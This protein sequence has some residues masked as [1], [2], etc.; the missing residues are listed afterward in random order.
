MK[1]IIP[2]WT[3]GITFPKKEYKNRQLERIAG[4]SLVDIKSP[5]ITDM[6]KVPSHGKRVED[7]M[8]QLADDETE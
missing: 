4:R 7:A 6:P 5:V 8:I 2:K 3:Y 1:D